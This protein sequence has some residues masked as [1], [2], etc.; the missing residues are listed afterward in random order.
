MKTKLPKYSP[1]T[2]GLSFTYSETFTLIILYLIIIVQWH[3]TQFVCYCN[4][5]ACRL[6]CISSETKLLAKHLFI[7]KKL[8]KPTNCGTEPLTYRDKT[9]SSFSFCPEKVI[10]LHLCI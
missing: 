5:H 10:N 2:S 1:F 4:T 9:V 6:F 8:Y 7:R 3:L